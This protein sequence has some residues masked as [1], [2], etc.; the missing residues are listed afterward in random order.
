V[1][2]QKKVIN[3]SRDLRSKFF[4]GKSVTKNNFPHR[5]RESAYRHLF[6]YKKSPAPLCAPFHELWHNEHPDHALL[7]RWSKFKGSDALRSQG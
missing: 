7:L 5:I 3:F 1:K 4:W 6:C 2:K